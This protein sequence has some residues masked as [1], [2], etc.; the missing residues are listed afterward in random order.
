MTPVDKMLYLKQQCALAAK[1][2]TVFWSA[3]GPALPGKERGCPTV[4]SD[5]K[6]CAQVSVPQNKTEIKLLQSIQRRA[7]NVLESG[8]QDMKSS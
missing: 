5:L 3:S 7:A 8:G 1:G 6:P 4:Q 2:P